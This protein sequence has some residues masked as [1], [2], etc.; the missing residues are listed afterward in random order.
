MPSIV[1]NL[2]RQ[3]FNLKRHTGTD[4]RG[5]QTHGSAAPHPCRA[6]P[7]N[8]LIR[9]LDGNTVVAEVRIFTE[10]EVGLEDL[11]FPPGADPDEVS[12]SKRPLKVEN[13]IDPLSG[14]VDHYAVY[15]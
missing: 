8:R 15:L 2:F 12:Q 11:V 9:A 13:A 1:R 6:E 5:D 3:T 4:F 10:A 7:F 14:A